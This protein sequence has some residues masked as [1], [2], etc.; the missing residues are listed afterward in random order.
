MPQLLDEAQRR[1]QLRLGAIT[2]RLMTAAWP[3]LDPAD[4]DAT[5]ERW[6]AIV[7][8]ILRRQRSAS[9]RL[10]ANYYRAA[11]Y[12]ELGTERGMQLVL[13]D[14]LPLEQAATSMLV[15]GPASIRSN[16]ARGVAVERAVDIAGARTAAAGMR[17]V[18]NGG[19][20]TIGATLEAD[21]RATGW[22]R[23]TSGSACAFCSMLAGRGAVY[24][25][26]SVDFAAHDH[27][28]CGMAPSWTAEPTRDVRDYAPS[29]RNITPEQRRIRNERV[30]DHIAR[31][32]A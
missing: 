32:G 7:V 11:R 4:L 31:T 30:R 6:L 20:E 2:V 22:Y 17:H 19:R 24:G 1:E 27:C 15:T 5:F 29:A 3:L 18:L 28:T 23:T 9:A 14:Q 16:L 13:A 10:A 25:K 21:Q 12:A 26:N 8:P